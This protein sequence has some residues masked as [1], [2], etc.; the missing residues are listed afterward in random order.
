MSW[1][2]LAL[3]AVCGSAVGCT[4][5]RTASIS[6]SD[7]VGPTTEVKVQALAVAPRDAPSADPSVA[8]DAVNEFGVDVFAAVRA[9]AVGENVTVSPLSIAI[10]LAIVEPGTSGEA[11]QQMRQLLHIADPTEF[12]RSMNSLEQNLD[13]RAPDPPNPGD[14]PGELAV[15]VANAAYLQQGY[16]FLPAYLD[17]VAANVPDPSSTRPTSTPTPT[18]SPIRSRLRSPTTTHGQIRDLIADG[19]IDPR[20]VLAL[21]NALYLKASWLTPFET[22]ATADASFTLPTGDTIS[23]PMMHGVSGSSAAGDGWVGATKPYVG[24]L[25]AQFILPDPGRFDDVADH[26]D[27]VFAEYDAKRSDGALLA[28][29]RLTTRFT[30]VLNDALKVLGLTAPFVT[31]GLLGIAN[32][33]RLVIDKAIHQAQVAIDEAGTEAAA[34]DRRADPS[35]QR[36]A[37]PTGAR[38]PRSTVHLPDSR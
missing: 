33:P 12:H 29:P 27:T 22:S 2:L 9:G 18:R 7:A 21:V 14:V 26:L 24:G 36:V 23:V 32:D 28:V 15:H 20:T 1:L 16:P 11:Q 13:G 17:A 31:G 4:S 30:T 10:A 5:T 6:T 34:G 25:N 38:H 3:A 8:A 19:V 35:L 37:T